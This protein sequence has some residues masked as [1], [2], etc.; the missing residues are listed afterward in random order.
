M[1]YMKSYT[2]NIKE[3]IVDLLDVRRQRLTELLIKQLISRDS[4]NSELKLIDKAH[5]FVKSK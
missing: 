5:K 3:Y 1:L 4:Y 2:S